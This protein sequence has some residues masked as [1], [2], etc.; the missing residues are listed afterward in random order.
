MAGTVT[1]S[2]T[3]VSPEPRT[4]PDIQNSIAYVIKTPVEEKLL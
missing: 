2:V 4:M 1:V 3:S